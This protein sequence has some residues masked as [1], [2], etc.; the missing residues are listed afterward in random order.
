MVIESIE[1]N[2]QDGFAQ[3][4]G[5]L[6]EKI[7]IVEGRKD[8]KA[9]R[10]LGI[11]NIILIGGNPLHRIPEKIKDSSKEIVILTDFDKKGNQLATKLNLFL[12]IHNKKV[13]KN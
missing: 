2:P 9:L 10:Q 12:R 1:V 11:Q 4:I 13:N 6:L 5:K 7:V 3:L 8:E